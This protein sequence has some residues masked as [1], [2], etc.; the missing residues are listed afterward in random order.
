MKAILSL[1]KVVNF[2]STYRVDPESHLFW[3]PKRCKKFSG[4]H[5]NELKLESGLGFRMP[6]IWKE[7]KEKNA[8]LT[9]HP[10]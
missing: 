7:L 3:I 9:G 8:K 1:F 6:T 10:T 2:L 5:G 4:R